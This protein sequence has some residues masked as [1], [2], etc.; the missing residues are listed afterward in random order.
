MPATRRK[1]MS[2]PMI[3]GLAA[4]IGVSAIMFVC[5]ASY[6]VYKSSNRA[7]VAAQADP[8]TKVYTRDEFKTMVD[9]KTPNEVIEAI[10][11]PNSTNDTS[12]GNPYRWHYYN[13]VLNPVTQ[14]YDT[15]IV[16]FEDGR[17]NSVQ[18]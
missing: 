17:A 13:K 15:G 6:V 5:M 14:K 11:R 2:L 4:A 3:L 12:L 8:S 7:S 1:P 10:G 18:W 9:G 16:Q